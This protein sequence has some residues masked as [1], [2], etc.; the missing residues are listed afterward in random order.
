MDNA[1]IKFKNENFPPVKVIID[2]QV[3]FFLRI[4]I[5]AKSFIL[6]IYLIIFIR[7]DDVKD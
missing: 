3:E 1:Q 7:Q 2:K 6:L 4:R 5:I